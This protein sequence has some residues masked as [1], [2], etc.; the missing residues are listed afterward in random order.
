MAV[1]LLTRLAPWSIVLL[2]SVI[3]W[4]RGRRRDPLYHFLH[5][6]W[7]GIFLFFAAASG[8][9]AVYLLPL[10]PA[11]AVIAALEIAAWLRRGD[12][13]SVGGRRFRRI[14]AV[15]ALISFLDVLFPVVVPVRREIREHRSAQEAFVERVVRAVPATSPLYATQDFPEFTLIVLAYRLNRN[16]P[17]YD[18]QCPIPYYSLIGEAELSNCPAAEISAVLTEREK[19]FY[20]VRNAPGNP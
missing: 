16:I 7:L 10:Y 18:P 6:W 15:C 3:Q 12:T 4:A 5:A 14:V 19:R 20:L 1:W 17:R 2:F 11:V 13:L 8:Q 9:R